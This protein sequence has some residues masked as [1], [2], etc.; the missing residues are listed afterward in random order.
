MTITVNPCP[1][2]ATDNIE[3]GEA[4]PAEYAVDCQE[5]RAIGPICGDIMSAIAAWNNAP[6]P[7]KTFV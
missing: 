7:L 2:C 4:G 5:C 6:R 3:I 1:F